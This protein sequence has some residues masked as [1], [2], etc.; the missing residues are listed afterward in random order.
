MEKDYKNW[1]ILKENINNKDKEI[2]FKEREIWFCYFG[3]N[4]GYEQDGKGNKFLRPVVI[5][6]KINKKIFIAIPLTTKIKNLKY[7]Y[8]FN[9]NNKENCAIIYQIK[10]MDKKRLLTKIGKLSNE[11]FINIKNSLKQM[12]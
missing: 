7:S 11:N 6:K 12:F 8:N 4:I 9:F 3:C 2:Y 10:L 5:I 1:H